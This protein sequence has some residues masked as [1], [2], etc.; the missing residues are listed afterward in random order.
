MTPAQRPGIEYTLWDAKS[1]AQIWSDLQDGP[2]TGTLQRASDRMHAVH[3]ELL[4]LVGEAI[5]LVRLTRRTAGPGFAAAV[6]QFSAILDWLMETARK[7]GA[8]REIYEAYAERFEDLRNRVEPPRRTNAHAT[9]VAWMHTDGEARDIAAREA[10]QRAREQMIEN[11]R[12]TD[13]LVRSIPWFD[14]PPGRTQPDTSQVPAESPA[15]SPAFGPVAGFGPIGSESVY[16]AEAPT[17]PFTVAPAGAEQT[18]ALL[19]AHAQHEPD[20]D[21]TVFG[22]VKVWDDEVND[23]PPSV[24]GECD[25]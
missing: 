7:V 3:G 18:G 25:R 24:I 2:R 13:S 19:P 15:I 8:T 21:H 14:P 20:Q 22:T 6:G 23:V 16:A 5:H 11:E 4:D 17:A 9:P 10:A 12:S 1:H